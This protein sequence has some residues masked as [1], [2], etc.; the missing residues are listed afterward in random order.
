LVCALTGASWDLGVGRLDGPRWHGR[1]PVI[2]VCGGAMFLRAEA[3]RRA[4][5]LPEGFEIYLDDLDLCL[6]IWNAGYTL[7]PCPGAVV[8]HKFSATFGH[9]KRARHKY[10]LNTRNRLRIILRNFPAARALQYLPALAVGEGRAVGRALLDGEPWRVAAH[11]RAYASALASMP[12]ALQ[13]RLHRRR[14]GVH[15]CRFWH[16]METRLM[17]C[18]GVE[19]PERGWYPPRSVDGTDLHPISAEAWMDVSAGRLRVTHG[20]CYPHLATT[21]VQVLVN[22]A[23]VAA[24]STGAVEETAIDVPGGRLTFRARHIFDAEA[25]GELSDYGGWIAVEPGA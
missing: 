22:G 11:F 10:Y 7:R 24:L 8:H 15:R 18:P 1:E 4:G 20:N 21:D 2:G 23:A 3:L 5:L 16:L 14:Q 25:T 12:G 17:F 19:I 9:G 6:R 13:E